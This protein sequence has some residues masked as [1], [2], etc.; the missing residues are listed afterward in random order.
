MVKV[1]V[2]ALQGDVREHV[3]IL[4]EIG[5]AAEPVRTLSETGDV[6]AI[7][8]PG[9]E[10]TTIGKLLDEHGLL[11]PIRRRILDGLPALGTC[12]GAILL[13]REVDGGDVP[14]LGV[15]DIRIARN[16]YGRQVDSF[17]A[18]V[19]LAGH[20]RIHAVFIRAPRI[21]GVGE[22]VEVLASYDAEPVVVRQ[23]SVLAATFHPELSGETALHERFVEMIRG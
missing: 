16:A 18:D 12:A 4:R 7:V 17:E 9:G 14:K 13:A 5:V 23:G 1:G 3:E 19:E 21:V 6:D 15:L 2:L 20:G 22:E 11:E 8:L 10:S